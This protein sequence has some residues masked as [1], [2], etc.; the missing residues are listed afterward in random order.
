MSQ[1]NY[2]QVSR[3]ACLRPPAIGFADRISGSAGWRQGASGGGFFFPSPLHCVTPRALFSAAIFEWQ[4]ITFLW[5]KFSRACLIYI[6][7]ISHI[8]RRL[9]S[10]Y[11]KVPMT[12][13]NAT[14]LRLI[15]LITWPPFPCQKQLIAGAYMTSHPAVSSKTFPPLLSLFDF[16]FR[17]K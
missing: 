2:N 6:D 5:C 1:S 7:L 12:Q 15:R 14:A 9:R 3:M 13:S 17:F 11:I 10:D 4:L 8:T 16:Y